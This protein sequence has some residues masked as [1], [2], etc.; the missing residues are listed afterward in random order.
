MTSASQ[1]KCVS[2]SRVCD[3]GLYQFAWLHTDGRVSWRFVIVR[4]S[5]GIAWMYFARWMPEDFRF[6]FEKII[7]G[8]YSAY[9]PNDHD[10]ARPLDATR[11]DLLKDSRCIFRRLDDTGVDWAHQLVCDEPHIAQ[12]L[13]QAE[14]EAHEQSLESLGL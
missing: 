2:P 14:T 3:P 7:E 5:S 9:M 1:M 8:N 11:V 6:C 12:L 13:L 10:P 4:V